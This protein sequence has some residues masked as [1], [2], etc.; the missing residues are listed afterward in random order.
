MTLYVRGLVA[1]CITAGLAACATGAAQ[2][3]E[4]L[5]MEARS[6]AERYAKEIDAALERAL[7]MGAPLRAVDVCRF[8]AV[9]AA[10]KTARTLG[11]RITRVSLRPYN[12]A[13]AAADPW[14]Q[15]VLADF[16]RRVSSGD[17]PQTLERGEVLE[18]PAGRVYRYLRAIPVRPD[19]LGCHGPEA[20]MTAAM[21]DMLSAS[22]PGLRATGMAVGQVAGAISIRR[23]F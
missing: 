11:W 4:A 18:E 22:Y 20:A 3:H 7:G 21:R 6:T 17:P 19:C 14:E 1:A 23:P 9:E 2:R 5:Q 8:T 12:P 10:S 16:E 15:Q 13:V